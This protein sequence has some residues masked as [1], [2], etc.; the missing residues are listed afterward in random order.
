M[1][2]RCESAQSGTKGCDEGVRKPEANGC[3]GS[4][5]TSRCPSCVQSHTSRRG[6]PEEQLPLEP[7]DSRLQRN[8]RGHRLDAGRNNETHQMISGV[9]CVAPSAGS[10]FITCM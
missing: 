10:A 1:L 8:D 4:K 2:S 7:A 9:C 3:R 6:G 5:L